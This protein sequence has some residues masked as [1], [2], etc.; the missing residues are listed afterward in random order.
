MKAFSILIPHDGGNP[1]RDRCVAWA[2]ARWRHFF[3]EAEVIVGG[4]GTFN[5]S[6][7]RN[8]LARAA[9]T[10]TLCFVDADVATAI[11]HMREAV[12][13]TAT[14]PIVQFSGVTW[15]H[16]AGTA[17]VTKRAP[18][19]KLIIEPGYIDHV[20]NSLCG[21][22]FC[23]RREVLDAVNGWDET[24][25]FWGTED[26]AFTL[27]IRC[28]V[29]PIVR[30]PHKAIHLWHPRGKEHAKTTPQFF[31][32]RERGNLYRH[33][34]ETRDTEAMRRLIGYGD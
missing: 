11:D 24:F 2:A 15:L 14:S 18:T 6:A 20:S 21:L 31:A 17:T 28:L 4:L 9:T 19:G 34:Y 7:N 27:A 12:T 32:N 5:R 8:M 13:L 33:A 26:L 25:Q 10:D 23:V 3:P 16:Q 1:Q 29:G 30:V 22:C